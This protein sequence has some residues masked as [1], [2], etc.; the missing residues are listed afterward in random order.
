VL[1]AQ[2]SAKVDF[3]LV[4]NQTPEAVLKGLRQHLDK[5]GFEDIEIT[6][7]GGE[8]P[9]RTDPDDPFVSLVVDTAN[10]VY[11]HPMQIV[12]MVGGSGPN[13]TFVKNLNLP[14]ATAGVGYPGSNAH[15]PNEN[16]RLDLYL[17]GAK[18]IARILETFGTA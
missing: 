9:A 8:A 2:A 10:E 13:H 17:L 14:I 4:P 3:R 7:L 12:P 18:H 1:P 5:E 15:A 11:D 6:Y 16:V